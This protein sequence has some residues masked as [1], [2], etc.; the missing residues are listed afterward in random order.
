MA[1][2]IR[3]GH[4]CFSLADQILDDCIKDVAAEVENI[5]SAMADHIYTSE[6]MDQS[7][8]PLAPPELAADFIGGG[9]AAQNLRDSA[10]AMY[11]VEE[12]FARMELS[13]ERLQHIA[14]PEPRDGTSPV[15]PIS[16][17]NVLM[18][19]LS[20]K[21]RPMLQGLKTCQHM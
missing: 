12:T 20:L 2:T 21:H 16:L 18:P 6:F 11:E 3:C 10:A 13:S 7:G 9:S 17:R 1:R 8:L 19:Q 14:S 4:F 5:S 15:N